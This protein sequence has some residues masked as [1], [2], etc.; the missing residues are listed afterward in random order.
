MISC[1]LP[2]QVWFRRGVN[3]HNPC[4]SGWISMVGEMSMITVGLNDQVRKEFLSSPDHNMWTLGSTHCC[5]VQV[6]AISCEDRAVCFR[7]SVTA[8]ELSG[9]TW[10]AICVPRDVDRSHSSASTNSLQR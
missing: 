9:K 6:F 7:Q 3:S 8:S 10:K 5:F 2:W 4:G 1:P